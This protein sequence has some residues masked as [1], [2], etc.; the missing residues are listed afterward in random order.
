[1]NCPVCRNEVPE[2]VVGTHRDPLGSGD[3][4]LID[5]SSCGAVFSDPMKN[6]GPEWYQRFTLRWGPPEVRSSLVPFWRERYLAAILRTETVKQPRILDIGCGYG[7]FLS[8]ARSRGCSVCGIDF[9]ES[10]I[11]YARARGIE[12]AHAAEFSAFAKEHSGRRFDIITFFQVLEH[13]DDPVSFIGTVSS[14][15]APGGYILFDVPNRRGL[16]RSATGIMDYPPHH[17]T[18]WD[19]KTIRGF[20]ARGGYSVIES[21]DTLFPLRH[22]YALLLA[23]FTMSCAAFAGRLSRDP[24]N[25]DH[26]ASR[27]AGDDAPGA[28][29][30]GIRAAVLGVIRL[31]YYGIFVPLTFP[32]FVF[33]V[34]ALSAG[35]KGLNCVVAARRNDESHH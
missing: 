18:R 34:P 33:L 12:D 17:L 32:A 25:A 4:R 7:A 20:L 5:C 28:A 19:M 6:P 26:P 31:L 3:Y 13:V 30:S 35:G 15:L 23:R 2:N 9:D 11:S 10:K 16:L 21:D 27:A 8:S 22:F 29:R 24:A 14:L 1:M